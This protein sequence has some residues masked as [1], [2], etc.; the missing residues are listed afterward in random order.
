MK[1]APKTARKQSFDYNVLTEAIANAALSRRAALQVELSV[2]LIHFTQE[3][4]GTDSTGKANLKAIYHG[5]GYLCMVK[6]D[7]DYKTVNRRLNAMAKVFDKI[8]SSVVHGWIADKGDTQSTLN[9]VVTELI[10]F[11]FDTLDDVLAYVGVETNRTR[12][13]RQTTGPV[14]A[15]VEA[16]AE[17]EDAGQAP[18]PAVSAMEVSIEDMYAALVASCGA[19]ELRELCARL[20]LVAA[21]KEVAEYD[22]EVHRIQLKAA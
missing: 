2:A 17:G 15:K 3:N 1:N 14:T 16:P 22:A 6:A 19:E 7:R 11:G 18:A 21:D 10:A 4:N 13:P 9:Y 12:T 20:L 5:A 8:G